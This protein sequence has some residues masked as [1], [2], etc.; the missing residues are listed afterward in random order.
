M[1]TIDHDGLL[2]CRIQGNL[3]E[4][5]ATHCRCSSPV[6]IRRFMNSTVA[7]R[8]DSGCFLDESDST[9]SLYAELE[10]QYGPSAY[11]TTRYDAEALYWMGYL[12]RYWAYTREKSSASIYRALPGRELV[13]QFAPLHTLDPDQA[14][15]RLLEACGLNDA[16]GDLTAKGVQSLRRLRAQSHYDYAVVNLNPSQGV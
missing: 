1:R 5:S 16:E 15:E 9:E 10:E 6:F 2:L 14:I 3:F 8:M 4:A 13:R 11:G 7:R 12:Y